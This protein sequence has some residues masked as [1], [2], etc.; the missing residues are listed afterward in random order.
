MESCSRQ[1]LR[2]LKNEFVFDGLRNRHFTCNIW[3][4]RQNGYFI[5]YRAVITG[6]IIWFITPKIM[7]L[8]S[9]LGGNMDLQNCNISGIGRKIL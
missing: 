2:K 3:S 1:I 6:D 4:E 7:N 5:F 9:L 8:I